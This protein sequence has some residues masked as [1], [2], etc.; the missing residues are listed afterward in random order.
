MQLVSFHIILHSS[1]L[2]SEFSKVIYK[3]NS[4]NSDILLGGQRGLDFL[5]DCVKHL[6]IEVH[7]QLVRDG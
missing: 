6:Q 2:T 7:T 4:I 3:L 1:L 5:H